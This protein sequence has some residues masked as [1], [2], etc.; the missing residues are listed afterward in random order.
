MASVD[1]GNER[2][3]WLTIIFPYKPTVRDNRLARTVVK[4]CANRETGHL[5]GH[6][7]DVTRLP[8]RRQLIQPL[9]SFLA[10]A[11]LG[12]DLGSQSLAGRSDLR[13][14]QDARDLVAEAELVATCGAMA[15]GGVLGDV[16]AVE[17]A[18]SVGSI[19]TRMTHNNQTDIHFSYATE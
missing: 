17:R 6:G 18:S 2:Q 5:V 15:F 11:W 9:L 10:P 7:D 8:A 14:M 19:A 16:A 3:H 12:R 13:A 4:D 1:E